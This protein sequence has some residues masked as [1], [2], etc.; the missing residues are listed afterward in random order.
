MNEERTRSCLGQV[1]HIR[2]P[3]WHRYSITVNQIMVATVKHSKW[4]FQLCQEEPL[5]Q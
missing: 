2:G 1:E 5:V 3:L 4:W